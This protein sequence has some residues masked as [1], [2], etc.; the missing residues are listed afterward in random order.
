[1]KFF[2]YQTRVRYAETDRMGISYYANYLVWFEAARTE[3]FRALGIVYSEFEKQG[4]FLPVAEAQ[5][6][7]LGPSSYD[8][9]L[10]VRTLVS[11]VRQSS[12]RFEYQVLKNGA[13]RPIATGYTIHVF[14]DRNLKPVRIPEVLKSK[15]EL[16]QFDS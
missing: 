8:D 1:M 10:T 7:Y 6:R 11:Q 2:D 9:L 13:A 15:V 3:Y 12:I 4:I 14:G 5:C 16:A